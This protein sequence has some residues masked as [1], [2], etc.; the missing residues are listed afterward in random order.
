MR[1]KFDYFQETSPKFSQ[2]CSFTIN[3]LNIQHIIHSNHTIS[4]FQKILSQQKHVNMSSRT[5]KSNTCR[6]FMNTRVLLFFHSFPLHF[7]LH[8]EIWN[9]SRIRST[10]GSSWVLFEL[11][12]L[13]MI[14]F[15]GCFEVELLKVEIS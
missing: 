12:F 13:V 9:F 8:D 7:T 10:C 3:L 11:F 14:F 5:V 4:T 15:G 2:N 6:S 1:Y